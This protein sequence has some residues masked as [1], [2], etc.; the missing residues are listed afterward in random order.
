MSKKLDKA[1]AARQKRW[2]KRNRSRKPQAL[3]ANEKRF[4]GQYVSELIRIEPI[5]RKPAP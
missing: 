4:I 2:L 1:R 3:N 5:E